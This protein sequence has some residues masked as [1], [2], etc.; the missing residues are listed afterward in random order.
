MSKMKHNGV[1]NPYEHKYRDGKVLQSIDL[2]TFQIIMEEGQFIKGDYHRSFLSFIYWFGCRKEEALRRVKEDFN[3][4]HYEGILSVNM[5]PIKEGEMRLPLEAPLD[6]PY[7]DLIA[8]QVEHTK[9]GK[10]VW[11]F[12]PATAWRIV[13]RAVPNLY[14]HFFRLNRCTRMLDDPS[15]TIPQIRTWFGWRSIKTVDSYIGLSHRHI[16][17]GRERLRREIQPL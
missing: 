2:Q 17:A 10:K 8:Y 1:G 5:P 11:S 9:E 12:H 15:A 14:P 16:E 6:L 13:K 7:V 4:N 3:I